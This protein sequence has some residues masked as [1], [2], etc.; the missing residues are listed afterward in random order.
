MVLNMNNLK[1]GNVK[2]MFCEYRVGRRRNKTQTKLVHLL[3]WRS[4]NFTFNQNHNNCISVKNL[5]SEVLNKTSKCD[6]SYRH[7]CE[8]EIKDKDSSKVTEP[9][10]RI[11]TS[12]RD[13]TT[14]R[15]TNGTRREMSASETTTTVHVFQSLE[16]GSNIDIPVIVGVVFGVCALVA[17]CVLV[18][19]GVKRSRRNREGGPTQN[20][21]FKPYNEN[22][23]GYKEI[24]QFHCEKAT[25][26]NTTSFCNNYDDIHPELPTVRNWATSSADSD[27]GAENCRRLSGGNEDRDKDA[28]TVDMQ[29]NHSDK[30]EITNYDNQVLQTGNNTTYDYV[31]VG[32]NIGDEIVETEYTVGTSQ[33]TTGGEYDMFHNKNLRPENSLIDSD[34]DQVRDFRTD[35]TRIET[36]YDHVHADESEI[37]SNYDHVRGVLTDGK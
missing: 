28:C 17:V 2:N 36:N 33:L 27:C 32:L 3:R 16:D 37:A 11:K 14:Q 26:N 35:D 20:I 13:T 23:K 9:N 7:L 22:T 18:I 15:S 21:K 8:G 1:C 12:I 5:G 6:E 31:G 4:Q 19:F 10:N 30:S 25:E 34:Y 29:N 24:K